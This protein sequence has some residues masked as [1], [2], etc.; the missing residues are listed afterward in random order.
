MTRIRNL[1][2]VYQQNTNALDWQA[3]LKVDMY[4]N[5]RIDINFATLRLPNTIRFVERQYVR[6]YY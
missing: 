6:L 1:C 3:V 2:S 5:P 4:V